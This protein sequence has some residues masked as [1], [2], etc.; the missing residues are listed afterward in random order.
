M[1]DVWSGHKD[2]TTCS[3]FSG[4]DRSPWHILRH[5]NHVRSWDFKETFRKNSVRHPFEAVQAAMD[6]PKKPTELRE[7]VDIPQLMLPFPQT[8][9]SGACFGSWFFE[10]VGPALT[11]WADLSQLP[12]Q[13][14]PSLP[15]SQSYRQWPSG[16]WSLFLQPCHLIKLHRFKCFKV[17]L[18]SSYSHF[19]V[20]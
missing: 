17:L 7:T 6:E 12:Y 5:E 1:A 10:S 9:S 4:W 14:I 19:L 13:S 2:G 8:F 3:C 18:K 16:V 15:D 11:L 20:R